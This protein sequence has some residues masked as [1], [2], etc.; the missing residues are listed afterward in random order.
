MANNIGGRVWAL[1]TPGAT[2]IFS[3]MLKVTM[4]EWFNPTVI[5]HLMQLTD[6]EDRVLLDGRAEAANQS[7]VFR[8][9]T[10][11]HGLKVP[12]LQ[13]GIVYIHLA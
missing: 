9:T 11:W 4:V 12:T 7:R 8:P 1:D 10:W 6:L 5:G 13:S 3:S 2:T